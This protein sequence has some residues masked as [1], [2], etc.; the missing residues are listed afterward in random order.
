MEE[1][2]VADAM[3]THML[4]RTIGETQKALATLD[5]GAEVNV[6]SP[7]LVAELELT[8]LNIKEPRIY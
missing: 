7:L 4:L 8:K 3:R 5:T 2:V 6:I 1:V